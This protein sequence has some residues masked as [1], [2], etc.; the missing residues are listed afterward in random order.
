MGDDGSGADGCAIADGSPRQ[1]HC[2]RTDVAPLAD[3]HTAQKAGAWCDGGVIAEA[4]IVM[5][6][7]SAIELAGESSDGVAADHGAALDEQPAPISA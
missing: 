6:R 3:P 5:K 1:H 2:G 7:G 4:D